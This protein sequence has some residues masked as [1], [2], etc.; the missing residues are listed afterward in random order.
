MMTLKQSILDSIT[1]PLDP[2]KIVLVLF[3]S[4]CD[5]LQDRMLK[6]W[7]SSC[8][9]HCIIS[10]INKLS[11]HSI[12][13]TVYFQFTIYYKYLKWEVTVKNLK[14]F[15]TFKIF[16]ESKLKKLQ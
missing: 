14:L 7:A 2:A 15:K 3:K 6:K 12:K 11:M 4:L 10:S 5:T 13:N 16:C 9:V 8:K 1:L